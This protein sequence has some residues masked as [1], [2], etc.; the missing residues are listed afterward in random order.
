MTS[1]AQ[2]VIAVLVAAIAI[3]V[4]VFNYAPKLY[5]W[6]IRERIRRIYRRLRVAEKELMT[7]LTPSAMQAIQLELDSIARAAAIVPMRNS[8]LFFG[9]LT[10]IDRTR[11]QL[12]QRLLSAGKA[13]TPGVA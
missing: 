13:S 9:L 6:F 11:T 4:P 2:R 7:E 5:L 3:V 1:Y 10:H 12:E 8:E